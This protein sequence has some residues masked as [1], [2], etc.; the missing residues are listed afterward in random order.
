MFIPLMTHVRNAYVV[1]IGNKVCIRL[2]LHESITRLEK[3][4]FDKN[5]LLVE[6]VVKRPAT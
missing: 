1:M 4:S 3:V 2:P 5:H 6:A